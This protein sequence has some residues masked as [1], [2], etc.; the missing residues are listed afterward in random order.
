MT[1][2]LVA[3][4]SLLTSGTAWAGSLGWLDEV[5]QQVVRETEVGG[6]AV[7]R[8]EGKAARSAGRLLV[9]DADESLEALARRSEAVARSAGKLDEPAEA[10][11]AMRFNRLVKPDAQMARTFDALAPAERRLVVEM[12]EAAQVLARRYP[13]QADTMIRRLGVEGLTAVRVYG[14]DVAEVI[15]KEG[16]QSLNVLR[17]AGRGG[18]QFFTEQV[19]PNKGKLAAAGVLALFLANPEKFVDTAGQATQFAVEQFAKAGIQFAGAVG[20]GAARGLERAVGSALAKVGLD[21][22]IVRWGIISASILVAVTALLVMIGM[23]V[24]IVLRPITWPWRMLARRR[25][26]HV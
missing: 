24:R 8:A 1:V 17:K 7:A 13:G 18:W 19:M 21:H 3:L 25:A 14:D 26:S 2:L 11:L 16:P 6:R 4:G 10:V 20:G 12:G 22:P 9:K 5:V 23:P 15:V